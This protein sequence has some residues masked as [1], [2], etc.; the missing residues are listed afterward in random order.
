MPPLDD[1][2][3]VKT[4]TD[5]RQTILDLSN[6]KPDAVAVRDADK[7][8]TRRDLA[9]HAGGVAA[10]VR[11]LP[12]SEAK[13]RIVAVL[14]P[15]SA[16][17]IAGMIGTFAAGVAFLPLDPSLPHAR[18]QTMIAQA[19]PVGMLYAKDQAA[20]AATLC[21]GLP[22]AAL[23][24]I[25]PAPLE[26]SPLAPDAA[27]Y[28]MFT[29]GSTGTPKGIL[30]RNKSLNHFLNWQITE[31]GFDATTTTAQL[32]PVTFDV[33]LR[34]ILAPLAAGGT[35]T[36]PPRQTIL[37]PRDLLAWLNANQ[38]TALHCVPS[39]LR[40]LITE[41]HHNPDLR[42]ARLRHLFL[43]GEPLLGRMVK[44]WRATA[45]D[46]CE[47]INF[48][49]PSETTLAKVFGRVGATDDITDGVLPIGSPL[50]NTDVIILKGDRL[51][52]ENEIGEICI[53]TAYPSLGYL[54][55]V[56]ATRA[57]FQRNPVGS[58]ANDIIYRSGDLG[59][60]RPD[61]QIECLGRRDGQV[62]IAGNRV[63][64]AEIEACINA[65]QHV[66]ECA[67]IV[68]RSDQ[69]AP[70][71]IAYIAG[72]ALDG[73]T[74]MLIAALAKTLPDYMIPRFIVPMATLPKLMNG[75][76]DKRALP[77]PAAMV[78]GAD[79]PIPCT[80]QTER[81]LEDIWKSEL[82]IAV[83]GA[84]T[85]FNNLGGD[86]LKA[87]KVLGEMYR[88]TGVDL[89]I[90]DFFAAKTIRAMAGMIDAVTPDAIKTIPMVDRALPVP[91]SDS[92]APLWA[93]QQI[94][95]ASTVYN[96]C[97]GF[98]A[99]T[100]LDLD[101]LERAFQR[102]IQSHEILR[103][104]IAD[105]GGEPRQI[106]A[107]DCAFK[108]EHRTLPTT[109]DPNQTMLDDERARPFDLRMPPLMRVIAARETNQSPVHLV[110]SFHHAICDGQSLNTVVTLLKQAYETDADVALPAIQYRDVVA[111]QAARLEGDAGAALQGYWREQLADAP[112]SIELPE[113]KPRPAQ[114]M[115]AGATENHNLPAQLGARLNDISTRADS[116][117]FNTLLTGLAV[118]LD[119]R[120]NQT[121]MVIATPVLGRNHPDLT[122]QIGFFAN[123]LCMRVKLDPSA[124]VVA[125]IGRVS[126]TTRDAMDHQDW[127]FHRLVTDLEET[128]DLS[129]NPICNIML[130]LFDA[131]RPELSLPGVA[132]DSFGRDTEWAFSRFDLVF[133]VTHDR[134]DGSLV[135]DLNYDTALF[136]PAQIRLIARHYE[137]ILAQM[138][139][140]ASQPIAALSPFSED[141]QTLVRD[142]DQTAN[143]KPATTLTALFA[144]QVTQHPDAEA[145]TDGQSSLSYGQ[146]DGWGNTVADMLIARGLGHGDII[147][148]S[149]ARAPAGVAAIIG[150]LKAG[151]CWVSLD[152]RW[153]DARIAMVLQDSK[154]AML[155]AAGQAPAINSLPIVA[156]P[157]S[158]A[159]ANAHNHAKPDAPAYVVY[160]SGSTGTPKGVMIAH[161]AVTNMVQ[162]QIE[163]MGLTSQARLL[164]FAAPVFD[165]HVSEL[166]TT[167]T[168][169]ATLIAPPRDVLENP[170]ALG[171][172]M[173]AQAI[174]HATIPPSFLPVIRDL[175]PP[176][177]R[178]MI[179]AGEAADQAA[180]APLADRMTIVN[181]YG[182][183]ENAV[184]STMHV[185]DPADP[186]EG[187]PIG[188]P[189]KGTGLAICDAN[190]RPV[191]IGVPGELVLFGTG[192]AHG[193]LGAPELTA[194]AFVAAE[195]AGGRAYLSGDI[196][197]LRADGAIVFEGRRDDQIKIAG[198]RI[199]LAEVES[200]LANAPGVAR[201][202]VTPLEN[203]EG[204]KTLGAWL[205][206][207]AGK[208]SL[209]PSVAE[210]FVYDDTVYGAMA[211]DQSRNKRYLEGFQR[212]LPDK[213][214]LEVG[215]G[216]YAILSRL[217]VQ[218]GAKHVT[219]VE[220]NPV[221]AD[222]ARKAVADHGLE[223]KIT[224]LTGDASTLDLDATF[225]WCISEI[226][227]GIGG[228]EGAADIIN[229]VR[230][231]LVDPTHMLPHRSL[232]RIAAV[233]LPLSDIDA[234]FSPIAA[235][236]IQRIFDQVG[237]P[238]D[239]RLCLRRLDRQ[240]LLTA[241]AAFEDLDFTHHMD[242]E[243]THDIALDAL[244]DGV[245]TGFAL[246]L[247]LDTGGAREIDVLND[248]ASWL[249]VYVPVSATG[250]KLQKGDQVQATIARTLA[251]GGR[252]PDFVIAGE[253]VR[254][255]KKIHDFN[256]DL[257]HA[258]ATFGA[259]PLHDHLFENGAPRL[260]QDTFLDTVR[261]HAQS[262]L[263]RYAV[264]GVLKEVETL[265]RSVNGKL[266][267]DELPTLQLTVTD[268]QDKTVG[269][270]P[271]A[272]T[273]A[274]VFGKLLRRD[275]FDPIA[276][277]FEQ[278][279]DSI[280]AVRAVGA[281]A[282]KGITLTAADILHHQ[283]AIALAGVARLDNNLSANKPDGP[284]TAH[285]IQSWFASRSPELSQRFHQ[286]I[287]V[288]LPA[289]TSRDAVRNALQALVDRHGAL[290]C[291]FDPVTGMVTEPD[292][293]TAMPELA[294]C[295]LRDTQSVDTGLRREAAAEKAHKQINTKTGGLFAACLL[296]ETDGD[297][298]LLV[299]HH[300]AVDL[301]SW[302]I[303]VDELSHMITKPNVPLVDAPSYGAICAGLA[304]EARSPVTTT[305]R[306]YWDAIAL[307]SDAISWPSASGKAGPLIN[308][309]SN[310]AVSLPSGAKGQSQLLQS[311]AQAARSTFGWC[312]SVID[313]ETHGRDLPRSITDTSR[314]VGW[315]T[316]ITPVAVVANQATDPMTDVLRGGLGHGLLAWGEN[317]H[318]LRS[319]SPLALNYL[320]DLTPTSG[321]NQGMVINWDGLGQGIDPQFR[322][323]NGI[324]VL[325]H[326]TADGLFLM[327]SGDPCMVTP[328][329]VER[330]GANLIKELEAPNIAPQKAT[331]ID[332]DDLAEE[333]G[334]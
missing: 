330:F 149:D 266:A 181:A 99:T 243:A 57:A 27:A 274:T 14:A 105:Q 256:V 327:V 332:I 39:L 30:G 20:L 100:G 251:A 170:P 188:T 13:P 328:D 12:P 88:A 138:T 169:G 68:D 58:Q 126:N 157:P 315:F 41:M 258:G 148:V 187:L 60:M 283:T 234:G 125:N 159:Q 289:D 312:S 150:I 298:L 307:Q 117:L 329:D 254:N 202:I 163:I 83:I 17:Q 106:I 211:G 36:V 75:K 61:G 333:L 166:F 176:S 128:R 242:L 161:S 213:T 94:D 66:T 7:T 118:A 151:A 295:D 214:V 167:F 200:T 253:I 64:T 8:L 218:A 257:P 16:D 201:A 111:W 4:M 221:V 54:K 224:I 226:V 73:D 297:W 22:I 95:M 177:L 23:D 216:P 72:D 196:A 228:S 272:Q 124:T 193:Y 250:F 24:R 212:H 76:L 85:P 33:S 134:R 233:E 40:L 74:S 123:T 55:D 278:G 136:D 120:A 78:H 306:P 132:L 241:S 245:L 293:V 191:P 98:T 319:A 316:R 152:E 232:T 162:Q 207:D 19:G 198:Q 81:T 65:H 171:K 154:A 238:F 97:F 249:P 236:Y 240:R 102:L 230:H 182:P 281:L 276:G 80:T 252:H 223:D 287:L 260:V 285:P 29:S 37:A 139:R 35:V 246:W 284:V 10:W 262:H 44:D 304:Q 180:L 203:A 288:K 89:K 104:G 269:I 127:P 300:L 48:Y 302:H 116:S 317:G 231:H 217:A 225:D 194:R 50:P 199:D 26:I 34:D 112:S 248:T 45:G 334:L 277:F 15:P 172:L 197:R 210:F 320:G 46:I 280:S 309:T 142:L 67:V 101:R 296:N 1:N 220:I 93:M 325:A 175:L 141:D 42:P 155:L 9:Q 185:F 147:A 184:C 239:L 255:G 52:L 115:F 25:A 275:N 153:P 2:T 179:T 59:R 133:H 206:K 21:S 204:R 103:T 160:T 313:L 87:I 90:A 323:G 71:L 322:T 219:A 227:G 56:A 28:V 114:Q 164:Q 156:V 5:F 261:T 107:D 49:G 165:A 91:L 173:A 6:A 195:V 174:T 215:P 244:R 82:G 301:V 122:D 62:K 70:F 321:T 324:S 286:S 314:C 294:I 205:L 310:V 311:M 145:M 137:S 143:A 113:A 144:E 273:I 305:E 229:N 265:P 190:Q 259:D 43:A 119:Q 53:R 235:D 247:T 282:A 208:A 270:P 178:V 92:Q 32:A 299:G 308:R 237:H 77:K 186:L 209:W 318:D 3:T 303:M 129:R 291:I 158:D 86:S 47:V 292:A 110:I 63:E 264:P 168:A 96:L 121:D 109:I 18:M 192:L 189:L 279:G 31:F 79:G 38:V 331:K 146:L 222:R 326:G 135:L 183:A 108:I 130:V 290:R 131:D 271:S 51:A 11:A 263:P 69:V 268:R 140:D 84:E 267:R